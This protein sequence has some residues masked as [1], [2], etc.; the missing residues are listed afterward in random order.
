MINYLR[1]LVPLDSPIRLTYHFWRAYIA[2]V[3]N[4]FPGRENITIIWV[5]WTNWKTTTTN[6]IAK[7][8]KKSW[9]KVFMFSTVNY[10]IW[11]EEWVNFTKMT[12]PDVFVMQK[13]LREAVNKWCEY[14]VIETSSHSLAMHRCFWIEYDYA[15]LTNITQDHLDLHRTMKNYINTKLK[16]FSGLI[17]N[18]RKPW[19]KKTAIIN[20]DIRESKIFLE[21]TYDKE[22]TYWFDETAWLRAANVEYLFD[23]MKFDIKI[24]WETLKIQTKLIWKFN[25]YNILSAVWILLSSW[26]SPR[27][28]EKC[29]TWV[30]YIPWRM[31]EV[32]N[33]NGYKIFIDYAHTEDA[34][35]NVLETVKWINWVRK[36][37][38]VFWATWDRDKTK[39]PKMGRVVSQNSDVVILTQDDDYSEDTMSI[40]KDV[41]PWIDRKQWDDFYIIS[42][43]KDAI[44]QALI[45]AEKWD[46]IVI[47]W[48]WDENTMITNAW[49]I[50][51]HDKKIT[52]SL[53][54]DFEDNK[55][56]KK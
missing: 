19:V 52:E 33:E 24:P 41:I 4:G 26:I 9:K 11:D 2:N 23:W 50:K 48:K 55:I 38:T 25:I 29:I 43:R 8:L 21:Q 5:T 49:A 47:A 56:I 39:R 37:I 1:K 53:L 45:V 12:S 6:I 14:A 13:M 20:W 35:E 31:E 18:K 34:L 27:E 32:K 46:V 22:L 44:R 17:W 7:S 28:I 36:I 15:V 54:K 42:D 51:W 30:E 40:I 3:L 10:M 16:L